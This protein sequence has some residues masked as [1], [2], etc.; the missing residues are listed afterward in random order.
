MQTTN[1]NFITSI[2]NKAT[3]LSERLNH[4]T[5]PQQ[6]LNTEQI[7]QRLTLWCQT[8]AKGDT[9]KFAQRLTWDGWELA[10]IRSYLGDIEY[11]QQP[12]WTKTLQQILEIAK[13]TTPE[14]LFTPQPYL[15]PEEPIG[16]EHFYFPCIQVARN[17]LKNLV[18]ANLQLLTQSAQISLERSLLRR[19]TTIASWTLLEEFSKFRT[20]GNSA[21]DFLLLSLRGRSRQDKYQEFIKKLFA[22]GLVEF[23]Q[24]YSVLARIL[25]Q[26]IDFWVEA[27]AEFIHRLAEDKIE[28]ENLFTENQ[29]L[30]QV[31]DLAAGLSDSHHRGRCVISLTFESGM[32]L[33][34]KPK[35]LSLDV[36]F[37]RIIDWYNHNSASLPLKV[38]K[39]LNR[40]TY[41]WVEYIS[42]QDCT[43]QTQ[44]ENFYQRMGMLMCLVYLLE[45]T[46]CH[47][48]NLIAHGEHPVL[49][50]LEALLQH[51]VNL[52]AST[53]QS[54]IAE[55][56]LRTNMLPNSD[57]QWQEKNH[58]QLFDDSAIG[59]IHKQELYIL[60]LKHI[61]TDAMELDKETLAITDVN[62]PTLQ[63]N[64]IFPHDYIENLIS[65]FTDMYR[66]LMTHQKN[67][68]T[69]KS[70]L[71]DLAHQQVR[72]VFRSTSTY[73]MILQNS[74]R[75]ILL[76]SGIDRSISLDVLSRAFLISDEKP[77]FWP[78]LQAELQAMEEGDIPFFVADSSSDDLILTN[79]E[80]VPK[81]FADSS[82]QLMLRRLQNLSEVNLVEQ[83]QIIRKS[84]TS[85][86]Q[87]C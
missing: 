63:G 12:S 50:D 5:L 26:T 57:I 3:T 83:I 34:Y 11:N 68:L 43:T 52:T 16:F 46:D 13:T 22:D 59:G 36:A 53:E 41:G 77:L 66:F 29:P 32:Q 38:I 51:R 19:F 30:G 31:V 79:G 61:N 4:P 70:C 87:T 7:E 35:N 85:R 74:Y 23:F 75:P 20:S 64:P 47:Y 80:T 14:Q 49:I 55:S 1:T 9:N 82:F 48:Q 6:P 67:L 42:F 18:G 10:K 21:R 15:N 44:A 60:T 73:G 28:I 33:I 58:Q 86:F 56:V 76:R 37:Y 84:L 62:S 45:G 27:I 78:I 69:D 54:A 81:L 24:E 25:A 39:I 71:R 2:I 17:Q 8:T 72:F 40:Q 65:G